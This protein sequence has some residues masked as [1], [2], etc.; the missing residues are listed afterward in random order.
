LHARLPS[1]Q[2]EHLLDM[3]VERKLDP[4]SAAERYLAAGGLT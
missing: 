2:K 1:D 4:Y 3:V